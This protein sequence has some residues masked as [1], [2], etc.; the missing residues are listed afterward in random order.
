MLYNILYI[1][2][3][4]RYIWLDNKPLLILYK[5][6][7][8]IIYYNKDIWL[9][10]FMITYVRYL[11]IFNILYLAFEFLD[12]LILNNDWQNSNNV[13][14]LW[15]KIGDYALDIINC[16]NVILSINNYCYILNDLESNLCS[17]SLF[18]KLFKKLCFNLLCE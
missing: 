17:L 2:L 7:I 13:Y 9:V 15:I 6:F 14:V 8:N 4:S 5:H 1:N 16:T 11:N 12:W 18:Y 3:D 10:D